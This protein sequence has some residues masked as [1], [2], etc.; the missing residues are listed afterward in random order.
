MNDLLSKL[1]EIIN[2][3]SP[4]NGIHPTPVPGVYC[5]KFSSSME[6]RMKNRWRACL[7][8]IAQGGK[9]IVLG[10]QVYRADDGHYTAALI[11]L[12]VLSRIISASPRKP[13]LV[14]LIDLDPLALSEAAAQFN[15][16]LAGEPEPSQRALFIGKA[17]EEMLEAAI[18]LAKLFHAPEDASVLGRLIVKE[19]FHY[20]L[21]GEN[22]PA[23]RRFVRSGSKLHRI[24]RSI[25][26]LRSDLSDEVDVPALAK[27]AN[28][29]RSAFFKHFKDVTSLSPIQYQKRLRLHEARRLMTEESESAEGS[30]FKVGYNSASQ[31][32]RE[33]SRMFG[34]SPLRDAI[35]V[36][37]MA[38][39][40]L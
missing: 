21:K 33:Y 22:G 27:A 35:N 14:L 38:T 36:K 6:R 12:P 16:E 15:G 8:I 19:M 5:I 13:F 32:S 11:E 23:I 29:S 26:G 24:F 1:T 10:R 4:G 37:K 40:E 20:L 18:R 3:F 7:A 2:I 31:F 39:V 28:M 34:N 30:A 17:S 25:H 9:E